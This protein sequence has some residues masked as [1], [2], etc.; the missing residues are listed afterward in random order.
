MKKILVTG[1]SGFLAHHFIKHAQDRGYFVLG[2]D[3]R[4]I[5]HGHNK[6]NYYIQTNIND[7]TYKDIMGVDYVMHFAWRTNI[8]DCSRHPI[9]STEQNIDMSVRMLEL[10][11]EAGVKKFLFP[12]TASLYGNNPTPWKEGMT[13]DPIEPYSWQK[14]SIEYAC[15][16][17]SKVYKLPTLVFRFFQV[18]GE[19]QRDDTAIAAFIRSK[20][21]GKPITLTET[22]AQSSFRSGQRDFVY[23]GDLAEA[24]LDSLD[25]SV[26]SGEIY[27]V[28]SGKIHT[29]EQIADA[30]GAEV[31]WIPKREY[32]V[33]RH[34]ADVSNIKRDI[35]WEATTDVI[36]W[37]KNI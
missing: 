3:K 9:E 26:G 6:P 20:K 5:P 29:M 2:V 28:A 25:V 22:T 12:S 32:E 15:Q 16:M 24:L 18:Y 30:L 1:S 8:P 31:T 33:E 21:N 35:G 10:A 4:P 23:A 36:N 13:P 14:L 19:F 7:L 34:L 11:R 37:L 17:Y 27:N